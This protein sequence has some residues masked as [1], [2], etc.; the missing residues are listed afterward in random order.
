MCARMS[1]DGQSPNLLDQ[2]RA[3]LRVRRYA[4]RTEQAY[5]DWVRRFV[6]FH[7]MRCREDLVEGTRKV[8]EFLT[9]LAV[10]GNVAPS[11]QNQA[12]NALLFLYT[13]VLEQPLDGRIDAVRARKA[14]RV[15]VVLTP[16]EARRVIALLGGRLSWW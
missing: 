10:E 1:P 15:P 12:L 3:V 5:C 4:F 9:H 11:T 2:M 7:R 13:Q 14:P 16:E 8:E 6:K